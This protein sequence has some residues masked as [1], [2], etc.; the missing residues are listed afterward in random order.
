MTKQVSSVRGLGIYVPLLA[1]FMSLSA[2]VFDAV[3]ATA[4][5][6]DWRNGERARLQ[7]LDKITAR[8]STIDVPIGV[9]TRF[10]T[11]EL[12]VHACNFRP[13]DQPPDHAALIEIRSVDYDGKVTEMPIFMGWMFASSPAISG[14]EHPVYDITVLS[15]NN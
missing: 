11:L 7:T 6:G 14:L 15:C 10:G 12:Y 9:T 5:Q 3:A 4:N 1:F 8:I 2:M 13:P